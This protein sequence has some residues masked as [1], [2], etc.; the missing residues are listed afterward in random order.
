MNPRWNAHISGF[1]SEPL[2][3]RDAECRCDRL[4]NKQRM[5]LP[6]QI[7]QQFLDHPI[8]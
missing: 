3:E 2:I 8:S 7:D 5:L 4:M 1:P 6:H